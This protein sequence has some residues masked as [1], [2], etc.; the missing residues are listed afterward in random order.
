MLLAFIPRRLSSGLL[1]ARR[2][3]SSLPK[4]PAA[5]E[6]AD[7]RKME[8]TEVAFQL[9]TLPHTHRIQTKKTESCLESAFSQY[10]QYALARTYGV[11]RLT[12]G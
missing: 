5:P 6:F 12:F 1:A 4:H 9:G 10:V 3:S 2:P 8:V 7:S 11:L